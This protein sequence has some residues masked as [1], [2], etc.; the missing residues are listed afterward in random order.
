MATPRIPTL[1]VTALLSLASLSPVRAVEPSRESASKYRPGPTPVLS[2]TAERGQSLPIDVIGDLGSFE[3]GLRLLSV[4]RPRLGAAVI[5]DNLLYYIPLLGAEGQ[6]TFFA[7]IQR[8]S[9]YTFAVQLD[10]TVVPP[11]PPPL[12]LYVD[13]EL[14]ASFKPTL[15][16]HAGDTQLQTM[17][18]QAPHFDAQVSLPHSVPADAMVWVS[19]DALGEHG[20]RIQLRAL[21]HTAGAL[22]A[23]E[24]A[25]TSGMIQVNA[26]STAA[27]AHLQRD[28]MEIAQP[29]IEIN[30]RA[31]SLDPE[32]VLRTAALL[33]NVHRQ[34]CCLP[35]GFSSAFEALLDPEASAW[36]Q[37]LFPEHHLEAAEQILLEHTARPLDVWHPAPLNLRRAASPDEVRTD[38]VFGME[39]SREIG[40]GTS[41]VLLP[42]LRN[43]LGATPLNP[44]SHR[45]YREYQLDQHAEYFA[46]LPMRCDSPW[47]STQARTHLNRFR[48]W[49]LVQ[50]LDLQL[51][52]VDF[53]SWPIEWD[54]IPSGCM[55]DFD[56]IQKLQRQ[57]LIGTHSTPEE[58]GP[59][60]MVPMFLHVEL[61]VPNASGLTQAARV[62]MQGGAF[63]CSL[64]AA[65]FESYCHAMHRW[66]SLGEWRG[67][68]LF[69]QEDNGSFQQWEFELDLLRDLGNP[70]APS[71]DPRVGEWQV[72]S[73]R[74]P[75]EWSAHTSIGVYGWWEALTAIEN[76][77]MESSD[78]SARASLRMAP[79]WRG[80]LDARTAPS[81]IVEE[82]QT[83]GPDLAPA[84]WQWRP[85]QSDWD[86]DV[87]RM[88]S[89]FDA[90]SGTWLSDCPPPLIA[91]CRLEFVR[92]WKLV[93][94]PLHAAATT[95]GPQSPL[96]VRERSSTWSESDGWVSSPWRLKIYRNH[97]WVPPLP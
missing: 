27:F 84:S 87:L 83:P 94:V 88:E 61:P 15:R 47:K 34:G 17:E 31:Q 77:W 54:P 59:I 7:Q 24:P 53:D 8:R 1:L 62:E 23:G 22:R 91:G 3:K 58:A 79:L 19:V 92:E 75:Q 38:G 67:F 63:F 20:S 11:P 86:G 37:D 70:F 21:G 76:G 42:W 32:A 78:T 82:L 90:S 60:G 71:A 66:N 43:A 10:L 72:K 35:P 14:P 85:V 9:G 4:E 26:L 80:F 97:G 18:L 50:V 6:E 48:A 25:L 65:G 44:W 52:R 81:R 73:Q 68:R 95:P 16:L 30:W 49:H 5:D 74:V 56:F 2:Y 40:S 45:G 12:D 93:D 69:A 51:V 41:K 13:V 46:P 36:L 33:D 28:G 55:L 39:L 96:L 57:Y 29:A 64:E 89:Y